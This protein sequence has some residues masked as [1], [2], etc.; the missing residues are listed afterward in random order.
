MTVINESLT[1]KGFTPREHVPLVYG[2]KR[3]IEAI[4]IHW[5]GSY[6]QTHGGVVNFFVN[7]AGNTSAHFVASG[8]PTPQIHCIVS[9][10]DAAW[11]AG[12][13]VGNA[14]TV[15]IELRPEAT[16]AD[17]R[18]AA[19]LVRFLRDTYGAH[20]P[21]IPHRDWQATQCPGNYDLG[22]IHRMAEALKVTAPGKKPPAPK[23]PIAPKPPTGDIVDIKFARD[24]P[25]QK[26]AIQLRANNEW[27]LKGADNKSNWNLAGQGLG[28]Y[29]I[30]LF[31]QGRELPDDGIVT[32]Q[33]YIV[34]GTER[35][36]SG[37]FTQDIEGSVGPEKKWRGNLRFKSPLLSTARI[38]VDVI[39]SADCKIDYWG[40]DI[41]VFKK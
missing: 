39:A 27:T 22:K 37:Y 18:V 13:A 28:Y 17:Y 14:T 8:V 36:R 20:L 12:N 19:E 3:T 33:I 31:I 29:D 34:T 11:H 5:W 9:P 38:E 6:G 4:T 25:G 35:K 15:G 10:W 7:G 1:A 23:P 2:R 16:E 21:L 32:V 26:E 40:A 41:Y 30:D 24:Y